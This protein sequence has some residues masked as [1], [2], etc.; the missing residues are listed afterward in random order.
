LFTEEFKRESVKLVSE[1]AVAEKHHGF[2]E[3]ESDIGKDTCFSL[4]LP[5]ISFDLHDSA[6]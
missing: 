5:V 3:V 4:R 2:A 6:E 1:Q